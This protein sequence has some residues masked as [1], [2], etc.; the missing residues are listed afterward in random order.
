MTT[1]FLPGND[2]DLE[3]TMSRLA[4]EGHLLA[5]LQVADAHNASRMGYHNVAMFHLTEA[6]RLVEVA[7]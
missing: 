2:C 7:A 1:I 3:A 5:A 4:A 6:Q